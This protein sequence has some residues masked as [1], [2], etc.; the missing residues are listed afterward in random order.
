M[1]LSSLFIAENNRKGRLL[2]L[3]VWIAHSQESRG[4]GVP[5]RWK[6]QSPR[7][8][9]TSCGLKGHGAAP[10]GLAPITSPAC[11]AVSSSDKRGDGSALSAKML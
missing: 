2:G 6:H 5:G 8:S 10:A 1:F 3:A 9:S 7:A 11:V 4:P